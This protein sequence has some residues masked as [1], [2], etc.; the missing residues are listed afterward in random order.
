MTERHL[1]NLLIV[2]AVAFAAPPLLGLVPALRLP[3]VERFE[4]PRAE[5]RFARLAHWDHGAGWGAL[6][7]LPSQ[8][9]VP[10]IF[11]RVC[12]EIAAK[13]WHNLL[14]AV[15]T[16]AAFNALAEDH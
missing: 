15:A 14:Y 10:P 16:G 6:V 5:Q 2:T 7:M 11:L 12:G 9:I 13:V 1:T 4:S 3:S 8:D